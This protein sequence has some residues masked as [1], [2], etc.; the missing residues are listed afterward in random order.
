[1]EKVVSSFFKKMDKKMDQ[2]FNKMVKILGK[3]VVGLLA[4]MTIID[5]FLWAI[6]GILSIAEWILTEWILKI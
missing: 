6:R 1:M 4:L 5:A 3:K 2:L